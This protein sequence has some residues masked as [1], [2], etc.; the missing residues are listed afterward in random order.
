[1]FESQQRADIVIGMVATRQ[2][3]LSVSL[4]GKLEAGMK[5][6]FPQ[7]S[8]SVVHACTDPTDFPAGSN[9]RWTT[10]P[11]DRF[12]VHHITVPWHNL[13]A[14]TNGYRAIFE[15]AR[16]QQA[17]AC[18]IVDP[19]ETGFAKA[20]VD[21][22]VRPG[23]HSRYDLVTPVYGEPA[24]RCVIS[25]NFL[26]PMMR[27]LLGG[28]P[29]L[30]MPGEMLLSARL[31]DRLLGRHDWE[32]S[33]ARYTPELWISFIAAAERFRL[34]ESDTGPSVRLP[35][36][37]PI[38]RQTAIAQITGGF[39]GL[40]EQYE[41]RW[42]LS[43][44]VEELDRFGT[45]EP[46]ASGRAHPVAHE[47]LQ[48]FA[49]A[50]PSLRQHW[51]CILH[52][53]TF[54]AVENFATFLDGRTKS[55]FLSDAVWV[56]IAYEF[57]AAWR[58]RVFSRSQII[59]LFTPLLLARLG[60]FLMKTE[61]MEQAEVEAELDRV[62]KYFEALQPALSR[63]WNGERTEHTGPLDSPHETVKAA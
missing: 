25:S 49:A 60:S 4:A 41:N 26:A 19:R 52:P 1:M 36:R 35:G 42:P 18:L 44:S 37:A 50:V 62:A 22:L 40:L 33:P 12:G 34:A 61:W 2:T 21:A 6:Y 8:W 3:E 43:D 9:S 7:Y 11:I 46:S 47:Y 38:S 30:P 51:R 59:G 13:P 16:K 55:C 54:D 39:F 17:T 63:L 32:S 48:T 56:R 24:R 57:A 27:A 15:F 53:H 23:I 14:K 45:R 58:C 10:I 20:W 31:M 28:G 29:R 5:E